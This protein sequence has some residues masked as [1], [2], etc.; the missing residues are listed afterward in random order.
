MILVFKYLY[1]TIYL[2]NNFVKTM[3][4]KVLFFLFS[5]LIIIFSYF[6]FKIKWDF[7]L[8]SIIWN[9][10]WQI[11][12]LWIVAYIVGIKYIKQEE[13]LKTVNLQNFTNILNYIF[14]AC[15]W[16]L[17]F[18]SIFWQAIFGFDMNHYNF[19]KFLLHLIEKI[20]Y[21][22]VVLAIVSGSLI[23]YVNR[24]EIESV[25]DEQKRGIVKKTFFIT[26]F[27]ILLISFWLWI[28]IYLAL[29]NSPDTDEI[30]TYMVIKWYN[31][32]WH[33]NIT[34]SWTNY[35]QTP[36]FH[37]ISTIFYNF[38]I[39]LGLNQ[40]LSL[41]LLNILLSSLLLIPYYLIIK[42]IFN[43]KVATLSV[44]LYIIFWYTTIIDYTARTYVTFSFLSFFSV[45]LFLIWIKL[46]WNYFKKWVI[47]ITLSI[48][49]S[50]YNF[51][52]G[53]I[54]GLYHNIILYFLGFIYIIIKF[55]K[56][57]N[58]KLFF[59]TSLVIFILFILYLYFFKYSFIKF[60]F[61]TYNPQ[62]R[63]DILA[64]WLSN[65]WY[66]YT[67]SIIL[68]FIS[69]IFFLFKTKRNYI[70]IILIIYI[71]LVIF[72]QWYLF[73][74]RF[75]NFKYLEDILILIIPI[76]S[77]F[78]LWLY[79]KNKLVLSIFLVFLIIGNI[80]NMYFLKTDKIWWSWKYTDITKDLILK[81][82]SNSI[83]ATDN[84]SIIY[85]YDHLYKLNHKIFSLP[86]KN[87]SYHFYKKNWIYYK[88]LPIKAL[89]TIKELNKLRKN[90]SICF[91]VSHNVYNSTHYFGNKKLFD[92]VINN[93]NYIFS[94]KINK[95]IF[96]TYKLHFLNKH[97]WDV[98]L[99]NKISI[100]N[101]KQN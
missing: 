8:S 86:S 88:Y 36:I 91:I 84:P 33:I 62:F 18:Q 46:I 81:C 42:K 96:S 94:K 72:I 56:N 11:I 29:N 64:V 26:I 35:N 44:L 78:L 38:W 37:Y 69:L 13:N 73:W 30:Y 21:W 79:K 66:S 100:N 61:I 55:R 54:L 74:H 5:S 101:K 22:L 20:Q 63:L 27:L 19:G 68:F 53:H 24:E 17:A 97:N 41:R 95:T 92:Y 65:L 99:F 70:N 93:W 31:L 7:F 25:E 89:S 59:F 98:I 49:L 90:N 51:I 50:F 23:F 1:I 12:I 34:P 6:S 87:D 16:L 83:I 71:T 80:L 76:I 39:S 67:I 57:K 82:P 9:P 75:F 60:F 52:D 32:F 45:F 10:I 15:L 14:L 3:W 28:K 43:Y 47:L 58:I 2:I 77:I 48:L 40:L 85:F 4:N